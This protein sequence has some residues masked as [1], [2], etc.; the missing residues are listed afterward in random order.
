M[1]SFVLSLAL[2]GA[3]AC[4]AQP[5]KPTNPLGDRPEVAEAGR[6]LYNSTCTG[7]H[8]P[9]GGEGERAPSLDAN[10]R[11]FRVSEAAIFE[12]VKNGIPGTAMPSTSLPDTEIW[13]IV[14]FIRNV[15]A[16]A[17]DL[18]VPGNVQNGM[19]VFRGEGGCVKC[20][21][22]RGQ[23][24]LL[25]PDLS[26]IGAQLPLKKL[27]ETLTKPRPIPNGFRPVSV[28]T[29]RGAAISGVARN[30]D[31]FS[32]QILD[33]KGKLHLLDTKDLRTVTYGK[34]SLMPHNFDQKLTADQ[35]RD[36]VGMLAVQA[37]TK[38]RA[39]LQGE[40]EAGR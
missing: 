18:V 29:L 34:E 1:K 25:G 22:I 7:C 19:L 8:G 36:L 21:M 33:D 5:T 37:R 15:R 16:T 28:T 32:L 11:Y 13:K 2:A 39:P 12:V 24:G 30:A 26:S 27:H 17:S 23:G 9:D 40:N 38:V 20:H 14:A 31:R 3:F 35:Y 6:Q 10:R 4:G